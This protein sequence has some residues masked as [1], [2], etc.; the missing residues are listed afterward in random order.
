[1]YD[2]IQLENFKIFLIILIPL[3]KKLFQ[4]FHFTIPIII[5]SA[6]L[7]Q[8]SLNS[9]DILGKLAGKRKRIN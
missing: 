1:M 6:A 5:N 9:A 7:A 3:L 2:Y 8:S 4:I